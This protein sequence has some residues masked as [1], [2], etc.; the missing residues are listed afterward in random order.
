M[1]RLRDRLLGVIK[2]LREEIDHEWETDLRESEMLH[3]GETGHS[4]MEAVRRDIRE[5]VEARSLWMDHEDGVAWHRT[6]EG[7]QNDALR[8]NE[9]DVQIVLAEPFIRDLEDVADRLVTLPTIILARIPSEQVR[10]SLDHATR[11]YLY[12]LMEPSAVLCRATLEAALVDLL[13]GDA[14]LRDLVSRAAAVG[15]LTDA[16]TSSAD[17]IR[18]IG[19]DAAHNRAVRGAEIE[20]ALQDLKSILEKLYGA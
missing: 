20:Q 11:C 12:G 8:M 7:Y 9:D 16:E 14:E 19:N 4:F 6:G 2:R 3:P 1:S 18:R 10:G 5:L 13:R 17:R 15:L